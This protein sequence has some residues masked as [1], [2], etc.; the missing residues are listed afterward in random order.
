[1]FTSLITVCLGGML[2]VTE[3]PPIEFDSLDRCYS[4]SAIISGMSFA[5]LGL[6]GLPQQVRVDCTG[7]GET[8]TLQFERD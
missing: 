3:V 4:V 1:M 2:C 7:F 6:R 8:H 5:S